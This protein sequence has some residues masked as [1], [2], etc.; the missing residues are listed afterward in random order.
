MQRKGDQRRMDALTLIVLGARIS[1]Q[2]NTDQRPF[3]SNEHWVIGNPTDNP[4]Q[5][6]GGCIECTEL[7]KD[8]TAFHYEKRLPPLPR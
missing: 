5:N 3:T 4:Y 8:G 2:K 7:G 1:R 6:V